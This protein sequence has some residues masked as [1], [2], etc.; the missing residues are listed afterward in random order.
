MDWIRLEKI[1]EDLKEKD[2][3][4]KKEKW[5]GALE[6]SS[7]CEKLKLLRSICDN[8]IKICDH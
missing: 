1:V 5:Y 2:S 3:N 8:R 6:G 7:S 4:K